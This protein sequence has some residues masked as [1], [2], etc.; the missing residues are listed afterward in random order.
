[1]RAPGQE[2][3]ATWGAA[4]SGRCLGLGGR[5]GRA[6]QR[7]RWGVQKP[8]YEAAAA[9]RPLLSEVVKREE[10]RVFA[11]AGDVMR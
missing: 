4:G 5:A 2:G 3:G 1:M 6:V 11:G 7:A 10:T 8:G 9:G